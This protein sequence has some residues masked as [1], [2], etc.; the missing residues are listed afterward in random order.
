MEENKNLCSTC[1]SAIWCK[2]WGQYKCTTKQRH[3]AGI[4]TTCASYK[5]RP[6]NW[7]EMP[8]RCKTCLN[9][10]ALYAEMQE[11]T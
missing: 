3:I 2:T 10:E 7:K 9:Y 1:S 11:E 6:A 8:C 5:K 4:K